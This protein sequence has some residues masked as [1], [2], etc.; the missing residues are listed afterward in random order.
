M[1]LSDE[2]NLVDSNKCLV[3]VITDTTKINSNC[4]NPISS[5]ITQKV[6]IVVFINDYLLDVFTN[7]L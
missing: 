7:I 3:T 4:L 2:S 1:Q 5:V 6:G